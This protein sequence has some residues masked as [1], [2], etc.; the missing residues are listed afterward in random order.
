VPG[1]NVQVFSSELT[2]LS[3]W[4]ATNPDQNNVRATDDPL[5]EFSS[6]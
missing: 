6:S 2:E 3:E 4:H 1:K 5:F